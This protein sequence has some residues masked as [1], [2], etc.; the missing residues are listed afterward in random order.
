MSPAAVLTLSEK[1]LKVGIS[2]QY[3]RPDLAIVDPVLTVSV[4]PHITASTGIDALSHAIES[5]ATKRF[6]HKKKPVSAGER[7]IYGGANV[8]TDLFAEKSIELIAQNL[9]K[10]FN[11]GQNL[12]ARKNMSLASLMA[13]IS[14][15]NAGLGLV[16]ALSF[17]L[18]E[19]SMPTEFPLQHC[20][21]S[22][23]LMQQL[24]FQYTKK[25][26]F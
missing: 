22:W 15:T 1:E 25:L 19:N 26:H 24:I 17:P 7:P 14:F 18:G 2:S 6:D 21:L 16:H 8:F 10:A 4:P 5:Y 11:N 23:N 9:R 12:E 20:L 13:G 3:I